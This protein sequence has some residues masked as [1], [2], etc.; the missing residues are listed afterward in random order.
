MAETLG[1]KRF[2]ENDSLRSPESDESDEEMEH[3]G[4]T[5][6]KRAPKINKA[7]DLTRCLD[8][9]LRYK[10]VVQKAAA[11]LKCSKEEIANKVETLRKQVEV[12]GRKDPAPAANV[13][14]A[15]TVR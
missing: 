6:D 9:L 11:A 7:G 10:K 1:G 8:T 15:V 13:R 4:R 3:D 12:L 5:T 2:E 14:E